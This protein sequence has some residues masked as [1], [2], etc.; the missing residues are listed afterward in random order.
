MNWDKTKE[1]CPKAYDEFSL[2]LL[3]TNKECLL[4]TKYESDGEILKDYF[5]IKHPNM[6]ERLLFDFFDKQEIYVEI[7]VQYCDGMMFLPTIETMWD[8][9]TNLEQGFWS[10]TEAEEKVY[11]KAFE[12]LEN[13][14]KMEGV[15]GNDSKDI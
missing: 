14:L 13:K 7:Q 9:D 6:F 2:W 1:K 3:R 15:T 8:K 10:R 11:E 5:T 4:W 12:I